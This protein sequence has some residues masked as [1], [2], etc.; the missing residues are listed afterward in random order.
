MIKRVIRFFKKNM[1]VNKSNTDIFLKSPNVFEI[2]YNQDKSLNLFK[3]CALRSFNVDY[4]PLGSYMTFTDGTMV[5]YGLS[6]QFQELDP[7]YSEDY[8]TEDAIGY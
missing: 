7:I 8:S 1:A 6:M 3:T 2:K 4:T 5:S